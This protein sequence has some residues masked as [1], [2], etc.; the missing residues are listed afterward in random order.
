MRRLIAL[1]ALSAIIL[2]LS[3]CAA[4]GIASATV[5]TDVPEIAQYAELFNAEHSNYR[6]EASYQEDLP[7]AFT[8]RKDKPALAIGRRLKASSLR[9]T[10]QSLD[11][12]F[13]DLRLSQ[14][15]FY[16]ELL[17]LGKQDGRQMYLPVSFNIPAMVFR[18]EN[19][20]MVKDGFFLALDDVRALG[21]AYNLGQGSSRSRMGFSPRWNPEFLYLCA[22]MSG[23][24]F[25]E[26]KPLAWN[27]ANLAKSISFIRQWVADANAS[28]AAE[29]DF[30]FKYLY[31]PGELSVAEGRILFTYQDSD[32]YFLLPEE[33]R[34]SLDFRWISSGG[35][36]PV[37]EDIPYLALC[38]GA[39]GT[40]AA[41]AFIAWFF[42]EDT[43]RRILDQAK[44]N[45]TMELSF[46]IAGGFSSLKQV[47]EKILPSFY[48]SLVGHL[49]PS[50][51]LDTPPILPRNWPQLK[52]G[53]VLPLLEEYCAQA[54]GK[55]LPSQQ[56]VQKRIQEW[57]KENPES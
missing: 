25:R 11:R 27:E 31:N 56:D 9:F 32:D 12:L 35:K 20:A 36:A 40:R 10:F 26:G 22:S 6:I 53:V 54:P 44:A 15:A 38:R 52:R 45:R 16:P 47:N 41:E 4:R 13:T 3:G 57:L 43:Q 37:C 7:K 30:Q 29:D 2:F 49:P 21:K 28:A 1:L 51:S 33:K 5:W 55:P 24:S 18:E 50:E 19:A 42:K 8:S 17:R 46:G 48:P 34:S 23:V 14:A 39:K